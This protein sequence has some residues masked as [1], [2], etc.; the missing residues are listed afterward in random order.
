MAMTEE[1]FVDIET[2][3][4]YQEDMIEE[5]NKVIYQQQLQLNQLEA[6]CTTLARNIQTLAA[7][8]SEGRTVHE[9][10]PHY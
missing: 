10:P 1:R 3:L 9:R 5:L 7:A 2:K 4:A 6:I 8:G